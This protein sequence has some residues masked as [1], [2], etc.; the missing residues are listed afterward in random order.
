MVHVDDMASGLVRLLEQPRIGEPLGLAH[1]TPVPFEQII[2]GLSGGRQARFVTVPWRRRTPAC[3]LPSAPDFRSRLEPTVC[4]V[5]FARR[6]SY[7]TQTHGHGWGCNCA[8][9]SAELGSGRDQSSGAS[10]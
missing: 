4:W 8:R 9:S 1:P 5:S 3:V 6:R 10:P 7:P 2:R